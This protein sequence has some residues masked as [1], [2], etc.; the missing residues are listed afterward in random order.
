MRVAEQAHLLLQQDQIVV[1]LL[2]EH[3]AA[4]NP[5]T[6]TEHHAPPATLPIEPPMPCIDNSPVPS[7]GVRAAAAELGDE[8]ERDMWRAT[9]RNW[10]AEILKDTPGTGH[11]QFHLGTLS[12]DVKGEELRAVYHFVKRW[13]IFTGFFRNVLQLIVSLQPCCESPV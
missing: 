6:L 3:H 2:E 7:V 13:A 12:R 10:Y 4:S 1:E 5:P 8:D 9:A 11:L